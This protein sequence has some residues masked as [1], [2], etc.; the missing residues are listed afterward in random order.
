MVS[1]SDKY[2]RALVTLIRSLAVLYQVVTT[3]T[4]E[5]ADAEVRKGYR[6]LSK[7]AHP[8][9]GGHLEDQQRLNAAYKE[10]CDSAFQKTSAKQRGKNKQKGASVPVLLP[11]QEVEKSFWFRSQAVL[12]TYQGFAADLDTSLAEWARFL[13]FVRSSLRSWCVTRWTA[14]SETNADGKHHAH[15]MMQFTSRKNR[16]LKGYCRMPL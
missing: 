8:D 1:T 16:N 11:T 14:S 9:R 10:W 2:K 15:L 12:F 3:V 6:T 13:A 5:S 7:K 4:R